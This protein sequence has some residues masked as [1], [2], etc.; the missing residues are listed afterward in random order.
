MTTFASRTLLAVALIGLLLVASCGRNEPTVAPQI[1]VTP[2]KVVMNEI[3]SRGTAGNLDWI[4]IYNSGGTSVD[5]S[6]YTIYDVG[7][8]G[9]T[10]AKKPFPTGTV[11]A[12]HGFYVI[13]VDTNSAGATDGFGLSSSGETV[14]LEDN[15]GV[16][17]DAVPFP[18]MPLETTSYG[19]YPDGDSTWAIRNTITKGGPNQP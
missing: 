14:W 7:G 6:G 13:T 8:Q 12:S 1:V 17:I 3:F 9:G 10:K 5:L 4:E 2:G 19:R 11:V 18:A 16:V 15:T